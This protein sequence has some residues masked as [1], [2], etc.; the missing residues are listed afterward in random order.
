MIPIVID[1]EPAQDQLDL[2]LDF[3][4]I[5][6][7]E[8]DEDDDVEKATLKAIK[9][10]KK[11]I[12]KGLIEISEDDGLTVIQHLHHSKGETKQISY[13]VIT[14]HAKIAMS[15]AAERDYSG[16]VYQVMGSLSSNISAESIARLKGVDLAVVECLG[17]IFLMV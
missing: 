9:K 8:L 11:Y 5:E 1:E 6:V 17:A 7:D 14:G 13:G 2:L 3:Y 4:D 12:M 15:K 16:K 10:I